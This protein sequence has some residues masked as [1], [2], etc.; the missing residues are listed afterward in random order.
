MSSSKEIFA[1]HYD[2]II[3]VVVLGL[4]LFSLLYLVLRG[5]DIQQSLNDNKSAFVAP[6]EASKHGMK[7]FDEEVQ[8]LTDKIAATQAAVKKVTVTVPRER[9]G[10]NDFQPEDLFTSQSRY[11]CEVCRLPIK[12]DAKKCTYAACGKEQTLLAKNEKLDLSDVDTDGDGMKDKWEVQYGLNPNAADDADT[13]LDE[14][15][16]SNIEEYTATTDPKNPEAH[17]DYKDVMTLAN[18]EK[19]FLRL[20]AVKTSP[21]GLGVN[22]E[23]KSINLTAIDFVEVNEDGTMNAKRTF[24]RQLPG[25]RIGNTNYRYQTYNEKPASM[26]E[27]QATVKGAASTQTAKMAVNTSTVT[28]TI[29]SEEALKVYAG[30]IKVKAERETAEKQALVRP[31]EKAK[32]EKLLA[33][34]KKLKE[35]DAQLAKKERETAHLT[36]TL[37]FYQEAYYKNPGTTWVGEPLIGLTADVN[38]EILP[39]TLEIK[40]LTKG[41]TFTVKREEYSVS[42]LDEAKE[43]ITIKRKKDG[44]TFKLSKK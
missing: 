25:A 20:R 18:L 36:Y 44:S 22:A 5:M 12:T 27:Y 6:T 16:F 7:K 26:L 8:A 38:V 24:T 14:D 4:L 41:A 15:G 29:M 13:D 9:V 42:S 39:E 33:A 43:S 1:R 34:E 28:V 21:G 31:E 19:K 23:G 10:E 17:P 30:Y 32:V 35:K 11:L 37:T 40:G 2:R 3:A